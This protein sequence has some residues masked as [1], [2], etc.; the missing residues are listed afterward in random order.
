M[1]GNNFYFDE[2]SVCRINPNPP[3]SCELGFEALPIFVLFAV[4]F[5]VDLLGVII[6]TSLIGTRTAP[7][8]KIVFPVVLLALMSCMALNC[9]PLAGDNE[10][11]LFD[12]D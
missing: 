1:I 11:S 4:D 7:V 9:V 12:T 6:C 5:D 3:L 2:D 8:I 10:W